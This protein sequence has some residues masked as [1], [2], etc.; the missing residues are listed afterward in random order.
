V[1]CITLA[2]CITQVEFITIAVCIS[3]A[4]CI[5]SVDSI[6]YLSD[7]QGAFMEPAFGFWSKNPKIRLEGELLP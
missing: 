3:L 4:E 1:V 6:P 7:G 2:E 5:T